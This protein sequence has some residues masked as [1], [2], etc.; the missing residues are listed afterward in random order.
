MKYELN[1]L[2]NSIPEDENLLINDCEVGIGE[3]LF[4]FRNSLANIKRASLKL[5]SY[6]RDQ[7]SVVD[8]SED[9]A[10]VRVGNAISKTESKGITYNYIW[11][12]V[13]KSCYSHLCENDPRSGQIYLSY[14]GFTNVAKV[15]E[16]LESF[17]LLKYKQENRRNAAMFMYHMQCRNITEETEILLDSS[18][19][20]YIQLGSAY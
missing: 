13:V 8:L 5:E 3:K 15:I 19:D 17:E 12:K 16:L 10:A 14:L 18:Y 4:S 6:I 2:L 1:D 9:S 11:I 7:I 20:F